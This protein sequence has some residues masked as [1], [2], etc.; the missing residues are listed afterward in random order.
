VESAPA[1]AR[2]FAPADADVLAG[3]LASE[4]HGVIEMSPD[5]P[6]LV[7][8]STNLAIVATQG[9][10]VTIETSQRSAITSAKLA[11]AAMV[12]TPARQAG[13]E[14]THGGDYPGWKPEPG[15]DI[16]RLAQSVHKELLGHT[17]ELMAVHAGLE[18]GVI[19]EKYAGMQMISFGPHMID[20]HSPNERLKISSVPP[21][22]KF[23]TGL[24]GRL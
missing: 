4:H 11:A 2:V 1:P 8:T 6:G 23:L 24:L 17:P 14:V 9:D 10:E 5:V 3:L 16:V 12:A 21:F 19:G 7:Q 18:C 22:W 20:V 13:F 15:S